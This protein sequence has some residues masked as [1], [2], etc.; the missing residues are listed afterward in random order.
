M[1]ARVNYK[2]IFYIR[3]YI[4]NSEKAWLLQDFLLTLLRCFVLYVQI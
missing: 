3:L 2:Y 4:K 1:Y